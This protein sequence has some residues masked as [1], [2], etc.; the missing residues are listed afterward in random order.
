MSIAA[1][2]RSTWLAVG[3]WLGC[4]AAWWARSAGVHVFLVLVI[5]CATVATYWWGGLALRRYRRHLRRPAGGFPLL[6]VGLFIGGLAATTHLMVAWP[7]PLVDA[8]AHESSGWYVAQVAGPI[9]VSSSD[10]IGEVPRF[11]VA[12]QVWSVTVAGGPRSTTRLGGWLGLAEPPPPDSPLRRRGSVVVLA[13]A[14]K[15]VS[16]WRANP[17]WIDVDGSASLVVPPSRLDSALDAAARGMWVALDVLPDDV[18]SLIAG[19][20]VGDDSRQSTALREAMR[21]SGLSHLTAVSGGNI[22]ILLGVTVGAVSLFGAPLRLRQGVGL[23]SVISYVVLVGPEPSVLRAGLMGAVAIL[24]LTGAG[25]A[26]GMPLLGSAAA[27]LL[28]VRPELSISWGFGLSVC[29]TAGIVVLGKRIFLVLQRR[30]PRI[31]EALLA[32][33]AV[34]M[35][36]QVATAPLLAAMTGSVS[37][38]ALPANV[39]A[40]PVVLPITVLG[41]LVILTGSLLPPVAVLAAYAAA[42]FGAWLSAVAYWAAGLPVATVSLVPGWW[43]AMLVVSLM[44]VVAVAGRAM[45]ARRNAREPAGF[46]GPGRACS[47]HRLSVALVAAVAAT[48]LGASTVPL[49]WPWVTSR[50]PEDWAV[51][52]CNVG[53]GDAYLVRAAPRSAVLVDTGR[54]PDLLLGCLRQAGV[55]EIALLVLTHYDSDHVGA[56]PALLDEVSVARVAGT[57]VAEPHRNAESVVAELRRHGLTLRPTWAGQRWVVGG[58]ALDVL[59]PSR[60]IRQGSVSNNAAV[61][62]RVSVGGIAVLLT[63]DLEPPAQAGLMAGHP[64]P[65]VDVVSVPHHGSASQDGRLLAWSGAQIALLSVGANRYGHPTAEALGLVSEG[66]LD[67][68]RSDSHGLVALLP[69]DPP[70]LWSQN[71]ARQ[72]N[73]APEPST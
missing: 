65:G 35:A 19:L 4:L 52:M 16:M 50:P 2:L 55:E 6:G 59:W 7:Q 18:G 21:D 43:G 38:A 10:V 36:A 66:G 23:A 60:V 1:D 39:L 11:S 67:L 72:L 29:A 45:L 5:A 64:P 44:I 27:V 14:T 8:A 37:L 54:D 22:S 46:A 61:A 12:V 13:G 9:T 32:A 33:L 69:G 58:A 73:S 71:Q 3:V 17:L 25:G 42:P 56:L 41:L 51:L 63:S 26:S 34:T 31:P 57:P 68:Y 30:W 24:A 62:V 47:R 40:A 28:V 70:R 48:A 15:P 49:W 20:A 53:Q